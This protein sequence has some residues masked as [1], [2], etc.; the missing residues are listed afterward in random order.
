MQELSFREKKEAVM[1]LSDQTIL[2]IGIPQVSFYSMDGQYHAL[3]PFHKDKHLGSFSYNPVT[4]I[5]KCFACGEGGFGVFTLIMK[6]NGWDFKQTIEYLHDHKGS[7]SLPFS[8][9]PVKMKLRYNTGFR[10]SNIGNG[11]IEPRNN[12]NFSVDNEYS[13]FA[14]MQEVTGTEL[15]QIYRSF[16]KASPLSEA[17][18]QK[19][20]NI[21]GL[22]FSSMQYFFQFPS[23]N[24]AN[25]WK[26]FKAELSLYDGGTNRL[27]YKLLNVSGFMWDKQENSIT[28]GQF[29][30]A[31][32]ILNSNAQGKVDS[33]E[34]RLENPTHKGMRY[35]AFS[36]RG[37]CERNP[38]RFECLK[39]S[40]L[41]VDHVPM[42]PWCKKCKGIAITE[43]K[44]KA[45][46]LSYQGYYAL[47]IHSVQ[48]WRAAVS[49]LQQMTNDLPVFVAL[50]ADCYRNQAVAQ[51]A[52]SLGNNVLQTERNCYYL[53][54]PSELGKGIDDVLIAGGKSH[55][56]CIAAEKFVTKLQ[57]VLT[58]DNEQQ[59]SLAC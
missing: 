44:F 40:T 59:V 54:W 36:A 29:G 27:F 1:A 8:A 42:A 25:F 13:K 48:N 11:K 21:R 56:R 20:K 37:I 39:G 32:G 24:D 4:T 49:A 50:D 28:F 16:A 35:M 52:V 23:A 53:A 15:D 14:K 51:C 12:K 30:E 9:P 19:L 46:Q 2:S 47:N 26:R 45:L 41:A 43:G 6:V 7:P 3:C 58:K 34:L 22:Y 31:I 55:I 18:I 33:I 10:S 17:A 5:W 57:K 38:E